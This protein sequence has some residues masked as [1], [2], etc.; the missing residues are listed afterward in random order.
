MPRAMLKER[1]YRGGMPFDK[2]AFQL[3]LRDRSYSFAMEK[4]I[5]LLAARARTEKEIVD[6]LKRNAYPEHVIARVMARLHDAGY[7]NDMDFAEHWAASRTN[8]GLGMRR[9]RTEL[10][11]KGVS[12][13]DIDEA[14][15]SIDEDDIFSSAVKA[16]QKASRGKDLSSPADRQKILAALARRGYDFSL[17]RRALDELKAKE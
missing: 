7:L 11:Q 5:A 8:K 1:P 15:S 16:A 10:R 6:A 17:A 2:A 12:Q 14:L 3:F 9:I 4:A 13:E